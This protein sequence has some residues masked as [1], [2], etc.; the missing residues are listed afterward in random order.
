[1]LVGGMTLP[2]NNDAK[3][4]V[5]NL[6]LF[7]KV[8]VQELRNDQEEEAAKPNG[9]EASAEDPDVDPGADAGPDSNDPPSSAESSGLPPRR[10]FAKPPAEITGR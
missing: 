1:M 8:S 10:S 6:Y 5:N 3:G 9:G 7:V 4:Q 2:S